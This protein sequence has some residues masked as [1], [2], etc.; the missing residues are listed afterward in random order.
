MEE[1][2]KDSKD[3]SKIFCIQRIQEREKKENRKNY[4]RRFN[5]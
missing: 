2:T 1:K 3:Y 4:H 5:R